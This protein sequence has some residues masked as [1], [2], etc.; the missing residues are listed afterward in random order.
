MALNISA[1]NTVILIHRDGMG[2]ADQVLRHKLLKTYL[3]LLR[4]GEVLPALI[5]FY[6]GGIK[7]AVK[8]SPVLEELRALEKDGVHM[9]L[10]GTC[11]NHYQLTDRVA[12]GVVGGM[13]D[14][15]EAQLRADKV[16][17]L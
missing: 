4:E 6:G 9:V 7:M 3:H 16:I 17:P 11:L 10:C 12:V 13:T 8:G 5:C 1:E 14:I 15:L 2:D